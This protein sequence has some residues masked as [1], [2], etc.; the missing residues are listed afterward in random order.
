M[1]LCRLRTPDGIRPALHLDGRYH[2]LSGLMPDLDGAALSPEGLPR[3]RDVNPAT[4]PVIEGMPD[5][6]PCVA[7][8]GKLLC[9]G[10]NYRAHAVEAGLEIPAE[11]ILFHKA[12]SALSGAADPIPMPEGATKLDW[13]VELALVIG[14]PAKR[15]TEAEAL[16]HVAGYAILNDVTDR[17]WQFE[18]GGQWTKGKSHDGFAPLGP[19]LVTADAVAD[20]HA[21]ELSLSVNG[22]VKQTGSTAD[23]IFTLPQIIAHLSRFMTLEPGDVI[24]TGTPPGVGMGQTPPE[25]LSVGDVVTCTV[26]G[27]GEQTQT[28]VE[29]T[30]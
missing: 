26:T 1:Q 6:A 22:A 27:L 21:L 23:L 11:P 18:R 29:D 2:D 16:D 5:Y 9:I 25:F 12:T 30:P 14:R 10:L 28:V 3:L 13:K 7:R 20:P 15:V 24:T 19:Y 4:L 8:P 17:A